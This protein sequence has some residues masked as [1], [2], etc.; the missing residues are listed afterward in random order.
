MSGCGSL[1]KLTQVMSCGVT[2]YWSSLLKRHG[3]HERVRQIRQV[4]A[5]ATAVWISNTATQQ[6]QNPSP[7]PH[8]GQ[9]AVGQALAAAAG[10]AAASGQ[11][12][13]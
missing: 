1:M 8:R 2:A 13:E 4:A 7:S 9:V 12:G 5:L 3:S 10:G 6:A 11:G